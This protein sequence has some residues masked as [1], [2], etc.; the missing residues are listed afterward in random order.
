MSRP[1]PSCEPMPGRVLL[2]CLST[3]GELT[4]SD[5]I[6]WEQILQLAREHRVTPLLFARLNGAAPGAVPMPV[7]QELREEFQA[8][9][10]ANLRLAGDLLGILSLF[11]VEG[12]AAVPF[13]GLMLASRYYGDIALREAGDLD[14]LIRRHDIVKARRLLLDMGHRPIFPTA[15]EAEAEFLS[16]LSGPREREYLLSHCEHHLMD[17][18]GRVNVDLHW[19]IALREFSLPLDPDGLWSRLET[20][21]LAG[22]P[23]PTLSAE[24]MLFVLCI[25]GGKDCW[26]RLDRVCDVAE[27]LRSRPDLDWPRVLAQARRVGGLRILFLGLRL[28]NQLLGA[29][30]P[31]LVLEELKRDAAVERLTGQ[32][33]RTFLD[34][35]PPDE[36]SRAGMS[37]F[38]LR[39]RERKRDRLAYC[40]AHLRPGVGDWV[41]L[42]LPPALSFLYYL[43][44]PFRLVVR[45]GVDRLRRAD[46]TARI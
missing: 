21:T 3:P 33:V 9:A 30:L 11:A 6:D 20:A 46:P 42:P 38:H 14:L 17:A 19:A 31:A 1:P 4:A 34:G 26:R 27:L 37:L 12:I 43:T 39:L 13:K 23:V 7:L 22:K 5:A 10:I 40:L 44:R 2:K 28:V 24:D 45:Y 8:N 29:T 18:A 32:V 41:S 36:S 25:N 35:S 16:R 15:S